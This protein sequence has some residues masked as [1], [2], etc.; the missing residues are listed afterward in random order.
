MDFGR[1]IENLYKERFW[2]NWGSLYMDCMLYN[3]N[4]LMLIFLSVIMMCLC[5][6]MVLFLGDI[7]WIIEG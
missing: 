1:E 5:R 3:I 4:V 2:D 6:K 7:C